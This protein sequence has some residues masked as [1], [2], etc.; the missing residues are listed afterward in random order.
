VAGPW[1]VTSTAVISRWRRFDIALASLREQLDSDD[2][3]GV[4]DAIA[5]ALDALYDLTEIVKTSRSTKE[6]DALAEG[7]PR[8]RTTLALVCARGGKTHRQVDHG[9]LVGFGEAPFGLGPFGGG[10]MWRPY[11]DPDPRRADRS[12][13]FAELVEWH[14]VTDP[15]DDAAAWLAE[16][17]ELER[18]ASGLTSL[19]AETGQRRLPPSRADHV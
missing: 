2:P 17:P 3:H 16:Q 19:C 1:L 6:L 9:A 14:G 13:W 15:F 18:Q 7:D 8:G 10:W 5:P 11:V 4:P 12:R